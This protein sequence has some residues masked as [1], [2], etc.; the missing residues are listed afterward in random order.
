MWAMPLHPETSTSHELCK[1]EDRLR[2]S[3]AVLYCIVLYYYMRPW[4]ISPVPT[5]A[6]LH[7]SSVLSS[8]VDYSS[9]HS[10]AALRPISLHHIT[11]VD[12][13][14]SPNRNTS[15]HQ[16]HDTGAP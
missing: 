9:R 14:P 13:P 16:R 2:S 15:A 11:P 12:P 6:P 7:L 10:H 3:S 5:L 8:P 4:A 1:E